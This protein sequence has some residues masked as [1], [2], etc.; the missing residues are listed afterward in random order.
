MFQIYK[1]N[2]KLQLEQLISPTVHKSVQQV[3]S[4]CALFQ[5][6]FQMTVLNAIKQLNFIHFS[7][8]STK[9]FHV[10]LCIIMHKYILYVCSAEYVC[11]RLHV[12]SLQ[13]GRVQQLK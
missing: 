8:V 2:K 7:C 6:S 12:S 5:K 4:S 1:N 10:K 13:H 9:N 11:G 3:L